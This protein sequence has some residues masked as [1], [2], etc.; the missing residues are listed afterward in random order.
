MHDTVRSRR[1]VLI[2]KRTTDVMRKFLETIKREGGSTISWV[3][4][5]QADGNTY[6]GLGG[7]HDAQPNAIPDEVDGITFYWYAEAPDFAELENYI[8]DSPG[9]GPAQLLEISDDDS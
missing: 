8:V 9:D 7:D 4:L 5:R 6:I 2:T 3:V 1:G